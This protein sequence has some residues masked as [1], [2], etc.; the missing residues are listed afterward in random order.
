M[1]AGYP[2]EIKSLRML[3]SLAYFH[4]VIKQVNHEINKRLNNS[5]LSSKPF[6]KSRLLYI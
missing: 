4:N 2:S 3:L 6:L 5:A 1:N